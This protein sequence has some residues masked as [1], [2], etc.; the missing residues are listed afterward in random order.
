LFFLLV[1][2]YSLFDIGDFDQTGVSAGNKWQGFLGLST[3]GVLPR[4][5]KMQPLRGYQRLL[6]SCVPF[7]VQVFSL[8]YRH[9][10]LPINKL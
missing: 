1:I 7:V 10:A 2:D 6:C 5:K 8:C 9:L 3:P 4:A